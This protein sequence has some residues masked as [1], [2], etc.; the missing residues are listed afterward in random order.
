MATPLKQD[1]NSTSLYIAKEAS[2]KTLPGSPVWYQK[3]PNSYSGAGATYKITPRSPLTNTRQNA[4]GTITDLDVSI[5]C[6]LDLTNNNLDRELQG[7]FFATASEKA[8][9]QTINGTA[10]TIAST[11]T[12][13]VTATSGLNVFKA[14]DIVLFSGFGQTAN[15][16]ITTVTTAVT[17][18][19]TVAKTLIAETTPPATAR[20]DT[21]GVQFASADAAMVVTGSTEIKL[22]STAYDF[23]TLGLTVGE[24][25]FIG[26]DTAGAKFATCPT[27]YARIASIA[28]HAITFNET[29]F[30]AVSDVGTGK[31]IEMYFGKYIQNATTAANIVRSTYNIERQVGTTDGTVVQAEYFTGSIPNTIDITIPATANITTDLNFVSSGYEM[32]SDGVKAGT[33]VSASGEEAINSTNDI[34]RIQLSVVSS[35]LNPTPITGYIKSGKISINNGVKAIKAVGILGPVEANVG[36]FIVSGTIEPYFQL[37]SGAGAAIAAGNPISMNVILSKNNYGHVFDIP[38]LSLGDGK[39]NIT[40]DSE[41]GQ[42]LSLDGFKNSAGYTASFTHFQYLPT[43]AM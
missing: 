35:A 19:L 23:T 41:I 17:G 37:L 6:N 36:N 8:G 16:G 20:I 14:K 27:G 11:T 26:S 22:T 34:Y 33:R 39:L 43:I 40:K 31:T 9:T 10:V 24:W 42:S 30:A 18:T 21:V 28:A 38:G 3:E 5:G 29:T 12:S 7:F 13:T 2:L 4:Q 25:V 1:S 15:N 32:K